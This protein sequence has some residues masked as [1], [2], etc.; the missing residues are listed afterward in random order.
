MRP[1]NIFIGDNLIRSAM[2][3]GDIETCRTQNLT[4]F[5]LTTRRHICSVWV[6]SADSLDGRL[7]S[8]THNQIPPPSQ[9]C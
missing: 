4:T 5:F 9:L 2:S 7:F 3:Y 8:R 6:L 1:M